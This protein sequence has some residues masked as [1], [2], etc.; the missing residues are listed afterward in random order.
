MHFG[1]VSIRFISFHTVCLFVSCICVRSLRFNSLWFS[2]HRSIPCM[3]NSLYSYDSDFNHSPCLKN[4]HKAHWALIIGCLID[5]QNRVNWN[6]C[7]PH[8]GAV[9]IFIAFFF[10]TNSQFY[11]FGRHGKTKNLALWPLDSLS[12]S[13]SNLNEYTAPHRYDEYSFQMPV[14]GIAGE[15]GLKNQC[16]IINNFKNIDDFIYPE[17]S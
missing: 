15:N 2:L 8:T 7:S 14:D 11:V 5:D 4:G 6:Q 1:L 10:H 12:D 17:P 16:I 13:N 9:D 3:I